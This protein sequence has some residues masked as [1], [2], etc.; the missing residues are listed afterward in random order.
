MCVG[1]RKD[2]SF[3]MAI[4]LQNMT[5]RDVRTGKST[6]I[7]TISS[8]DSCDVSNDLHVVSLCFSG[9]KG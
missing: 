4:M 7:P 2:W 5:L 9:S 1:Q 8:L 6:L 3:C